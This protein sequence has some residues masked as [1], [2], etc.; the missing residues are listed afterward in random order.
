MDKLTINGQRYIS[1]AEFNHM[2]RNLVKDIYDGAEKDSDGKLYLSEY[3]RGRVDVLSSIMSVIMHEELRYAE[4]PEEIRAMHKKLDSEYAFHRYI[5]VGAD[6]ETGAEIYFRMYCDKAV[7]GEETPV[8]TSIRRLSK[9]W[10]D[11][12]SAT[13]VCEA[14]RRAT[15]DETLNVVPAWTRLLPPGEAEHRLLRAIFGEEE[16]EKREEKSD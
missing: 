6:P 16:A 10:T 11:H 14:L 13:V 15:G 12:Y 2:R 8:F 3:D 5:I 1:L 9:A 4:S 7:E